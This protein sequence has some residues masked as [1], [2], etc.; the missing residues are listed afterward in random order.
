MNAERE[1]GAPFVIAVVSLA[2]QAEVRAPL[3]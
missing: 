3:S 1:E 2:A